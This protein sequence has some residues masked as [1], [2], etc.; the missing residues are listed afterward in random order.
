[1]ITLFVC[2]G[3]ITILNFQF[4]IMNYR[5]CECLYAIGCSNDTAVTVG[6]FLERV[7]L[8]YQTM[9]VAIQFL[10]PLYSPTFQKPPN[11]FWKPFSTLG[12]LTT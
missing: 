9:V 8:L 11:F 7:V 6:L 10:I 1:M 12:L 5:N 2:V 4:S 3:H